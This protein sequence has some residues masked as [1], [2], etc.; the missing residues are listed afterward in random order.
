MRVASV[1]GR[2]FGFAVLLDMEWLAGRSVR[3]G[4]KMPGDVTVN[5]MHGFS[6]ISQLVL[7]VR[8]RWKLASLVAVWVFLAIL[9][10]AAL[11]PARYTATAWIVFNNRGSDAIVDKNESQGFSAYVNGEVDLIGSQRV[12]QH[13]AA[14]TAILADPRTLAQQSRHQR[15]AAPLAAWLVDHIARNITVVSAKGTRTVSIAADFD[16]PVW[17]ATIANAVANSYLATAVDLKVS[18]ARRNVVFFTAQAR[19]RA[20]EM[21]RVQAELDIFLR[22]TGMT[23]LEATSDTNELQ[24]RTFAER[25]GVAATRRAGTAAESRMGGVDSAVSAGSITSQVVQQLRGSIAAQAAALGELKVLSG[26][27]FPAVIEAQ[28]RLDELERQLASELGK[29]ANGINRNNRV[30]A[31]E[32][33]QIG[34]L[35]K[36]KRED[37]TATAANR[38]RL[39]VLAGNVSRAKANYDAVAAR[40]ADVELQSALEAPSAAI[41]SS[42]TTPR[43]ASFPRWPLVIL[44]ALAAAVLAG[45]IAGLVKEMLVPR[46][47][48]RDDLEAL[49]GGVPVLC[50]LAA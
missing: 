14:N 20:A 28:A 45:I 40:L 31:L 21:R 26:P 37:V 5:T 42:A 48:S 27:N 7:A 16:D 15:G 23:G 8:G 47:R 50:D 13:V 39:Q 25:A 44:L 36:Q 6:N 34:A 35:E 49:L 4:R 9:V 10:I 38:A 2:Q 41:L 22:T 3:S 17:A 19:A 32:S 46:V 43:G 33:S 12:L 30:A 29:V 11:L 1:W 18:P 24:L